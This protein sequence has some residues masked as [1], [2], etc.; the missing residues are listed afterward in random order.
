[1]LL[2]RLKKSIKESAKNANSADDLVSLN[3][4]VGVKL[5]KKS[6]T[7]WSEPAVKIAKRL[8]WRAESQ[9]DGGNSY[10]HYPAANYSFLGAHPYCATLYSGEDGK[11][12]RFSLVFANKG[13]YGSTSG[14]GPDHF[15]QIHPDTELPN[16]LNEAIEIDEEVIRKNLTLTL[17]QEPKVQYYGEK[18]DKRKVLRWDAGEHAFLLTSIED[19]MTSLLIV[20]TE[21]ADQQGKVNLL[22]D[23]DLKAKL[24]KNVVKEENGD[25]LITNIPMVDQGPKGYCAPASFERAMRYMN[26]PAD[27]Y[28]LATAATAAGGGTNT[29]LLADSCKRIVRSKARKIRDISLDK[30]LKVRY[31]KKFIDKGV[32]VLWQMKSLADYNKIANARTVARRDVSD[33]S[34]WATEIQA[35][36]DKVSGR[37][38]STDGN[39]HI[40]MIIGYNEATNE[41]AV[42]DSWGPRYALRWVSVDIAKAVTTRGG[43]V[44][45]F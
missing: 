18:E 45:D 11:G 38:K 25:V 8:K 13:D 37:L 27:M 10:R 6:E 14:I 24:I 26:I 12:E 29:S 42:S 3:D 36:A 43:F 33:L 23:S 15:K 40:C 16:T 2:S 9:G 1:M 7:L 21:N 31:V 22:K 20:P 39:Y 30:D 5:F 17:K 32:P 44:I 34:H 41:L 4:I 19:E 28:L 35:E